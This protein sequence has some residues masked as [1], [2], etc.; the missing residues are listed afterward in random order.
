MQRLEVPVYNEQAE[1]FSMG[2]FS[3]TVTIPGLSRT[4]FGANQGLF[5]QKAN[6]K[7]AAAMEAIKWI[8]AN[9]V[10]VTR[11]TLKKNTPQNQQKEQQHPRLSSPADP[12]TSASQPA[13]DGTLP[14][15]ASTLAKE[16]GINPPAYEL[17]VLG[18]GFCSCSAKFRSN[19]VRYHPELLGVVGKVERVY[20]RKSA[21]AESAR[22]VIRVLEGISRR[23]AGFH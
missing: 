3:C 4:T 17:V 6:A 13:D 5:R 16:L 23:R 14:Q 15:R 19:D 2:P 7:K 22:E 10:Q 20:G 1:H 21:K 18:D 11:P 8:R 9:K 12:S